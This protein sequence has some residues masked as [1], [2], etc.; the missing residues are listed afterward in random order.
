MQPLVSTLNAY[1]GQ[2]VANAAIVKSCSV[3][4]YV[5]NSTE[6]IIDVYGYFQ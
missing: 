2:V 3:N 6:V 4:V 1:G 5:T